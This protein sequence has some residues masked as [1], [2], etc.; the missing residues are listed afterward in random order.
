VLRSKLRSHLCV[1]FISHIRVSPSGPKSTLLLRGKEPRI[2]VLNPT[3]HRESLDL[4]LNNPLRAL[5]SKRRSLWYLRCRQRLKA[6]RRL[7]RGF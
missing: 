7:L 6:L 4:L 3:L 1:L 5:W 2:N